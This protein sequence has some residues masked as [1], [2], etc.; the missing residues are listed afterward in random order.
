M[1][2]LVVGSKGQSVGLEASKQAGGFFRGRFFVP[3]FFLFGC[4]LLF[5]S[6]FF[7][8]LLF[9]LFV[10][11]FFFFLFVFFLL[12]PAVLVV[13]FSFLFSLLFI[14]LF[15]SFVFLFCF[16]VFLSSSFL[17]C[18]C[19]HLFINVFFPPEAGDERFG[20]SASTLSLSSPGRMEE[21]MLAETQNR[22]AQSNPINQPTRPVHDPT[23]QPAPESLQPSLQ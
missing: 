7:L 21:I 3:L 11:S 8:F 19:C 12:F 4:S 16:F 22:P 14:P 13:F 17:S 23:P 1:D 18:F 20:V 15:F 5:F 2:L 9:F 10:C 6:L